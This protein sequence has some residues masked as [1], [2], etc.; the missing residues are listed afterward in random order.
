MLDLLLSPVGQIVALGVAGIVV[1]H[2]QGRRRP[3]SRLV[4]QIVVFILM[5]AVLMRS[6]IAP[7]RFEPEAPGANLLVAAKTLWWV[8]LAWA[9]T[10]FLRLYLDL[11]GRPHEARLLQDLLVGII[12]L[13]VG[14]AVLSSG[15]GIAIGTLLATSGVIAIILGVALQST[16]ND[17]FSGLALTLGRPYAIGDWIMLAD[18]MQGRVVENSWRSTQ[19]L[20]VANNIVVLPNSYLAKIGLT[21]VSHPVET[22]Q[23]TLNIRARATR[24][25][26]QIVDV[27]SKAIMGANIIIQ[28]PPPVVSLQGIDSM[29]LSIDIHVNV[30]RISD[31]VRGRNEVIDLIYRQCRVEGVALAPP[32]HS[33]FLAEDAAVAADRPG[34]LRDLLRSSPVFSDLENNDLA[35]LEAGATSRRYEAGEPLVDS[36]D[37][38]PVVRILHRGIATSERPGTDALRL[39]PGDVIGQ[40][41]VESVGPTF[42]ALT[43]VTVFELE[44]RTLAEIFGRKPEL[45]RN[46][47]RCL[48]SPAG[49][50]TAIDRRQSN[51][52]RHATVFVRAIRSVLKHN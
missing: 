7:T 4:V 29:A 47:S 48:S 37:P 9:V 40:M 28:E 35:T 27:V 19:I 41:N 26:A 38:L 33:Y 1:W 36:Q 31:R 25:P 10:G 23:I 32:M 42:H 13:G 6:G 51:E 44:G 24:S 21:N 43:A 2:L 22:H 34:S 49:E 18:G 17:V 14:L 12:Y 46:L 11:D 39:G 8:H 16:L 52:H 3:N 15:F 30:R 50:A 45:L 5:T 20:T